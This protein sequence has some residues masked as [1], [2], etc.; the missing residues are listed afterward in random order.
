MNIYKFRV[1]FDS[2]EEIFR[3]IEM[4]STQ[5]FEEFHEIIVAA[6]GFDNSQMASFYLSNE[7]WDKGQEITLFDMQMAEDETTE[8]VLVMEDIQV[9]TQIKGLN[10]H[11]LYSYDFLDMKNFFI[12]LLS[13]SEEKKSAFYPKVVYSQ[14]EIPAPKAEEKEEVDKSDMTEEELASAL[15]AEAGFGDEGDDLDS[16]NFESLDDYEEY[17]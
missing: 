6:F 5:N 15:L 3:D 7:Q 8:L 16:N 13:V 12:E 14:G 17:M 10:D 2:K 1:L 9:K 11:F 4:K